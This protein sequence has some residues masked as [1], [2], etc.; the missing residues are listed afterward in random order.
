MSS[1][2]SYHKRLDHSRSKEHNKNVI[3]DIDNIEKIY[4]E[5]DSILMNIKTEEIDEELQNINPDCD[6]KSLPNDLRFKKTFSKNGKQGVVGILECKSGECVYKISQ[7]INYLVHQ[8]DVILKA[9]NEIRDYCPHFCRGYGRMK[10]RVSSDFRT[11]NNPFN[12]QS[13]HNIYNDVL[14]MEHVDE[15]RKFYRYIKSENVE[16]E[17]LYSIIK[18]TL[19]GLSI[20]QK[21][22][23]LTHYDL[24]S[25][26]ILIK[27]CNPNSVFLYILD[28]GK[29]YAVPTYGYYPVIIDF[30]FGYVDDMKD[31]PLYGALAHTD[32]GFNSGYYDRFADPKLFLV[33]VSD[34]IKKHRRSKEAKSLRKLVKNIFEPLDIDWES[35]WDNVHGD[36]CSDMIY[37][38]VKREGKHSRFFKEY[39]H[40]CIDMLQSLITV[41]LKK[42]S[43]G[44]L[45]DIYRMIVD[46][47]KNIELEI[48][49]VFYNLVIF[50]EVVNSAREVRDE[51]CKK[52]SREAAVKK[53]KNKVL[54]SISNLAKYCSPKLNWDK[55][56]CSLIVFSREMEGKMYDYI[57]KQLKEKEIEYSDM[58]VSDIDEIYECIEINM[59]GH[60]DFDED[61]EIYVWDAVNEVS[62]KFKPSPRFVKRINQQIP[63]ERGK[64]LY[65]C[66]KNN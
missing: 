13:R 39:G 18:Q 11:E 36:S 24:H 15:A 46:E 1:R 30:G 10:V 60:F 17:V 32:A 53:F 42:R 62:K 26:N 23:K 57:T 27:T 33:T 14:L 64:I 20:A 63:L 25:N 8:E 4:S 41:P 2:E 55:L 50:K 45:E 65:D 56:L 44:E 21:K 47:Y 19:L 22:K 29:Y 3:I 49:S 12:T 9:L 37:N 48:S 34:E 16:E 7:T 6:Y 59:P 66:Y 38:I 58:N 52:D 51:Y 61:T 5:N 35:G 54:D 31:G 28:D 40:Y 43:H